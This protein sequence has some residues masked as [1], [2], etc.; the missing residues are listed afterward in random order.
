MDDNFL[1]SEMWRK[2]Q[3]S[4]GRKVFF[5]G[6]NNISASIIEH[7]LPV[8][9][10]YFYIPRWPS[11]RI[12]NSQFLISN[13]I[14]N[15]NDQI[16][17]IFSEVISLA[18]ENNIGWIRIDPENEKIL[19]LVKDLRIEKA[20]HDMQPKEN[21]VM[22]ITK[23]EE[24]LL[25]GMKEKT[26]YNIKLSQ[27]RGVSVKVISNSKFLI[28]NQTSNS[29]DQNFKN[30]AEEFIKL[31][32]ITSQRKGIKSHPENYY[33]KMLE[34]I[35][36]ENLKLYLAE[37]QNAT[38]AGILVIY[39]GKTA[40]YLHGASSDEFR[41]VMAPYLLQWQA[42]QDAKKA[43]M[44][45][46]DF[47]GISTN[48]ELNTNIRTTSSWAGIT[49]FKIGFSPETKSTEFPGSYDIVINP[50]KYALYRALQKI[51]SLI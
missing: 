4:V 42:I 51:K 24:E 39:F 45:K 43:G 11:A 47:G 20:P 41:N 27:K 6:D 44:E 40:T 8:A 22:S 33:R 2:F 35:P 31:I 25:A 15:S 46:Y 23:T 34:T 48:Y 9:G 37:Y 28:S 10:R 16:S 30:Y 32:K 1:Q 3:A 21:F 7:N 29:N 14:P 5:I 36:R 26:R 19:E 38:I 12:S 18:K 49:K 50:F 17:K 13:K